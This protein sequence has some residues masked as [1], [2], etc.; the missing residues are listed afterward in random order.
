MQT[1]DRL[2]LVQETSP[3]QIQ[4]AIQ[5]SQ[6]Y[7]MSLQYP[8]GYWWSELESNVT[9]T[10][11]V[12]IL[13]KIWGTDKER[14]LHKAEAYLRQQQREHGGWDCITETAEKLVPALKPIW[15]YEFWVYQPMI[16]SCLKPKTLFCR[17]VASAKPEFLLNFISL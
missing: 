15:P 8:D 5:A 2:S 9:I 16:P 4:K 10:A 1:D 17:K 6:D 13:H 3:Q 11:E 14:P 12:V 7:L